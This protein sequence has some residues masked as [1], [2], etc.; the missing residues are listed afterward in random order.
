MR[1]DVAHFVRSS[2]IYQK[3]NP[4]EQHQPFGKLPVSGLFHS[5]SIVF[6]G[7]LPVTNRQSKYLLIAVEH[8]SG[9]PVAFELSSGRFG[10]R[11]FIQFV[12][13]E[14]ITPF[15]IPFFIISNTNSKLNSA[16]V[17]DFAKRNSIKG[18]YTSTDNQRGNN[19]VEKMVGT[20]KRAMKKVI[21]STGM[22]RCQGIY[23]VLRGYRLWP[24]F[25]LYLNFRSHVWRASQVRS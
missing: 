14:I 12:D 5:W 25:G 3:T 8:L 24:G 23:E 15:G 4:P 11:G 2:D 19:K 9:W 18:K 22:Q 17:E 21:L 1:P 7:P 16:P 20:L 13:K 10:S 6:A